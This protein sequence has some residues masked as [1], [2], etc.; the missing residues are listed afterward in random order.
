M[1]VR[2]KK[3]ASIGPR[4]G[5]MIATLEVGQLGRVK[6]LMRIPG[7]LSA[8]MSLRPREELYASFETRNLIQGN[9]LQLVFSKAVREAVNDFLLPKAFSL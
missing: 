8:V 5:D 9:I 6:M 4:A 7:T 1:K 3:V 2:K